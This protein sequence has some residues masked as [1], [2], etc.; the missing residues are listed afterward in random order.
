[1]EKLNNLLTK[2]RTYVIISKNLLKV[3]LTVENQPVLFVSHPSMQKAGSIVSLQDADGKTVLSVT[4]QKDFKQTIFSSPQ[5]EIG[6][7]YT[8]FIDDIRKTE[9]TLN[10]MIGKTADDGGTFTGGYP[11]G[12]W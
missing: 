2:V 5:L 8:V 7:T 3:E 12:H 9:I 6:K 1:M 4:S 10:D 11:R